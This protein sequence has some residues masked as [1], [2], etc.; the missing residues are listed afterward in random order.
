MTTFNNSR[1]RLFHTLFHNHIQNSCGKEYGK[2]CHPRITK[3]ITC[4]CACKDV[5][6]DVCNKHYFFSFLKCDKHYFGK[7]GKISLGQEIPLN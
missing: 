4:F 2:I 1:T 6:Q 3:I 7:K 5:Q